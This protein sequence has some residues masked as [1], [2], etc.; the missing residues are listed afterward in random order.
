MVEGRFVDG[1]LGALCG[2]E[3]ARAPRATCTFLVLGIVAWCIDDLTGKLFRW[4][5]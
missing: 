2:G 3:G 1:C 4:V 5:F